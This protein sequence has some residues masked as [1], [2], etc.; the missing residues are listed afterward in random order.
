MEFVV[1]VNDENNWTSKC[2]DDYYFVN[3]LTE[4]KTKKWKLVSVTVLGGWLFCMKLLATHTALFGHTHLTFYR[5]W[6]I[7]LQGLNDKSYEAETSRDAAGWLSDDK[8]V[9]VKDISVGNLLALL[10][11]M[12]ICVFFSI[13][14]VT[15]VRSYSIVSE[16]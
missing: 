9:V 16:W 11:E 12:P 8:C 2:D 13:G 3:T 6:H 14:T 7:N 4:L 15:P 10:L 1:L 5:V